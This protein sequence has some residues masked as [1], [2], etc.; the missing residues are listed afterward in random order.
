MLV[1]LAAAP[2]VAFAR[3]PIDSL[4]DMGLGADNAM[5]IDQGIAVGQ[6]MV[7][8]MRQKDQVLDDPLLDSYL[9]NLGFQLVSHSQGAS[10]HFKF[11]WV[12]KSDVNAFAMPGGFVGVNE[13]LILATHDESELAAVL[14]HEISH[15][16]QRHIAQQ[17]EDSRRTGLATAAA[18]GAALLAGLAGGGN[19]YL[20]QAAISGGLAGAYQHQVNY[21]YHDEEQADRI[22]ESL[23]AQSG[24]NPDAMATFFQRLQQQEQYNEGPY[25]N[26]L[27]T[28][29]VTTKRIANAENIARQ[30]PQIH[31]KPDASYYIA[32]ARVRVLAA[33]DPSDS[34]RYF[35]ARL[36]N[37]KGI[38]HDAA[39]YGYAL[40]LGREGDTARA[41]KL[42]DE[43]RSQHPDT[44]A[45]RLALANVQNQAGQTN[46][47]MH[48]YQS[49]LDL[50]PDNRAVIEGYAEVLLQTGRPQR[51]R[52]LLL[53]L[54]LD[55]SETT[56]QLRLLAQA[57]TAMGDEA[58]SHYYMSEYY[59]ICGQ[60]H[61]AL[62]QLEIGLH[63]GHLSSFQRQRLVSRRKEIRTA[64]TRAGVS[65]TAAGDGRGGESGRGDGD[66]QFVSK[67]GAEFGFAGG[68]PP[69]FPMP[70]RR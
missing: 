19:P 64:M 23:L 59:L 53:R 6:S 69:L 17:M 3:P 14:A 20:A 61:M 65:P 43:L 21:T 13:G 56:R 11:L 7:D 68:F 40:S 62:Q 32:R 1:L 38:Q 57:A 58:D 48:T 66:G 70:P 33:D 55:S 35:K 4:P 28:H 30:Y 44:L 37:T 16:T 29:P 22:G 18:V 25:S 46:A 10:W 8:Q 52:S 50:Y 36:G 12:G 41:M 60:P 31:P 63:S 9:N 39:R 47:S 24:F 49:A 67:S 51:A 45:Y 42:L 15:V 54:P 2:A 27:R 26:F 5:S 34:A